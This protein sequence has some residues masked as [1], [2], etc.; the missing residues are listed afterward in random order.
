LARLYYG[1]AC[2]VGVHHLDAS[3]RKSIG[4]RALA[5][6]NTT[7]QTYKHKYSPKPQG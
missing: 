6:A 1:S 7:G 5:A 3:F 4:C 2:Y